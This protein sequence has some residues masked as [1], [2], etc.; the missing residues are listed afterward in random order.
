MAPFTEV[1]VF[2]I[3]G[4]L[5]PRDVILN[6]ADD[7]TAAMRT[8]NT[9]GAWISWM[10]FNATKGPGLPNS[11]SSGFRNASASLVIGT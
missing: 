9:F 6:S 2:Q 3:G 1:G 8:I 7:L 10:S 4:R 11:I 5:I